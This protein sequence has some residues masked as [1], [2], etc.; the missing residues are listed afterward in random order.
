MKAL[1]V[2]KL[3]EGDW[4]CEIKHDGYRTPWRMGVKVPVE[5]HVIVFLTAM[6]AKKR[7]GSIF[8]LLHCLSQFV[9]C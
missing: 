2:D 8:Q 5:R 9:D 7:S 3:P 4:L 1:P 6:F